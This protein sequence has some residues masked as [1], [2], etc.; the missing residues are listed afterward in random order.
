M[1]VGILVIV[2]F[3]LNQ[4]LFEVAEVSGLRLLVQLLKLFSVQGVRVI[5]LLSRLAASN[6]SVG[7]LKTSI[8]RCVSESVCIRGCT[9]VFVETG[10][11]SL[12]LLM[13]PFIL[14]LAV[15]LHNFKAIG[16]TQ[17]LIDA[18]EPLFAVDRSIRRD[19]F[20]FILCLDLVFHLDYLLF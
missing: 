6:R 1:L 3:I 11:K 19:V 18:I 8:L 10:S 12:G 16:E 13:I 2:C 14:C 15:A 7:W 9:Q 20:K 5:V 4:S 17:A